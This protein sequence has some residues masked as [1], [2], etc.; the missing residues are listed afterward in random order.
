[1]N[2]W[3]ANFANK[4]AEATGKW[5]A[6]VLALS[7]VLLWIIGGFFIGF[8][9][10]IYQLLINTVTTIVTFLLAFLIQ[11]SANIS[12]A[13]TQLKLDELLLTNKE[14]RNDLI[15]VEEGEP[16][17]IAELQAEMRKAAKTSQEEGEPPEEVAQRLS[18]R[19]G[20]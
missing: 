14:A 8:D 1:M 13:A 2:R 7:L 5:Y 20:K 15:D 17:A 16:D 10:T 12:N 18:E 6:F 19:A 9:N 3:F 11:H 4:A